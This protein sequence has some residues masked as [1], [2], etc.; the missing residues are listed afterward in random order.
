MS[1]TPQ[2]T[3]ADR[4]T[5]LRREILAL[6]RAQLEPAALSAQIAAQLFALAEYQA[7]STILFYV[8]ARSE[9][10]TRSAI[11]AAIAS[12]KS[13]AVPQ[14]VGDELV[15][16]RIVSLDDLAPGTFGIA[17][18]RS[19][20]QSEPGRF[21]DPR[22]IDFVVTP[23]VAFDRRGHRLGTGRGFYDRF[24]PRLRPAAVVAGLAYDCQLVDEIPTA[25]HDVPLHIVITPSCVLRS[26]YR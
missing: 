3:I 12:G 10:H 1:R 19:E 22:D 14:C 18:L 26:S 20:L 2:D 15:P 23:G 21:V 25:A 13:V 9:V 24:L 11:A 6:R 7:A 8:A 16:W 4:K 5:A 17:E